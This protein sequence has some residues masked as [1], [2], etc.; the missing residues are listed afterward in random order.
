MAG[1]PSP[2]RIPL[3][4]GW[5]RHVRSAV[6]H[7]ISLA[8]F[9]LTSTRSWA[10]NSW[11]ARVRLKAENDRLK[12]E[13]AL[14]QEEMRIKDSRMLRIP[15]Q[16]RPHYPPTERLSILELRAARAWSLSQTARHLL[17]TTATVSSWMGRLNEDG[18]KAL[19]QTREPVNKFPEFVAYMVKR[20]KVLCP[21]MGKVKAA[22]MFCRAG[23]HLGSTTVGRYWKEPPRWRPSPVVEQSGRIVRAKRPDHIWHC[24]LSVV[25]TSFGFWVSWLP[26]ALPQRWPFCWWIAVVA[27]HFSRRIMGFAVFKQQP[28]SVAVRA[29][30]GR[31]LRQAVGKPRHLITDQGIQFT[32]DGF[33]KW[34]RRR[35]IRQRFGAVGK[36]GSIAVVE[37]L[38]RSIKN[39]CTR[40]LLVPYEREA[41]RCELALY[42]DW[43]NCHRPHDVLEGATPEEIYRGVLPA[44][45]EPR[46]E[47]RNRW[48]RGSPCAR[49]TAD[50]RGRRGARLELNVSFLANRRH[51]PIVEIRRAA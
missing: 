14:L 42:V 22:Q 24:D 2:P 45:R 19:V 21:T 30:L 10:V 8:H 33:G 26:F 51:L 31:V 4:R 41:L 34:C 17:I 9:S 44:C 49:P 15:A 7:A 29:F 28:T 11:N 43:Y 36:Y 25:P 50:V 6:I 35:R 20:L 38:I 3:P 47:P 40:R 37:R 5:P 46:F 1:F 13:L 48:P 12:Q 16:R 27:D 18:P 23:L 39:E 32:D